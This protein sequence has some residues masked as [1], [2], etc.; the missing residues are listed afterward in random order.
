MLAVIT[1]CPASGGW[2]SLPAA[3]RLMP[4]ICIDPDFVSSLNV[5]SSI[6]VPP[7]EP[8]PDGSQRVVNV[9]A[10]ETS[11]VSSTPSV[12]DNAVIRSE[13]DVVVHDVIDDGHL[14]VKQS[15]IRQILSTMSNLT[16]DVVDATL[17]D[18][19]QPKLSEILL[20]LKQKSGQNVKRNRRVIRRLLT[21]KG[22]TSSTLKQ[23]LRVV[24]A[25][26]RHRRLRVKFGKKGFKTVHKCNVVVNIM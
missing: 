5:N 1:L 6:A 20:M 7:S 18:S 16:Y 13:H 3:F 2:N 23:R 14:S 4:Y 15:Q 8:Q 17:L 22:F 24:R 19:V 25:K 9:D 10:V 12:A 26:R 11:A 21:K